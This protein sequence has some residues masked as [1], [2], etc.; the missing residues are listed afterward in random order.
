MYGFVV[1]SVDMETFENIQT[2]FKKAINRPKVYNLEFLQSL[3][4]FRFGFEALEI[5]R[6]TFF[7]ILFRGI[8]F[9]EKRVKYSKLEL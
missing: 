3:G 4:S 8:F 2:R 5:T 1:D 6:N 9:S 7:E